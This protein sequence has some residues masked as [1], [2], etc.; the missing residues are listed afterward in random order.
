MSREPKMSLREMR[1]RLFGGRG[2]GGDDT[3]TPGR[4]QIVPSQERTRPGE[5]CM[6]PPAGETPPPGTR[7]EQQSGMRLP[8]LNQAVLDPETLDQLFRDIARC[9]QVLEVIPRFSRQQLV[10]HCSISLQ[11]GRKLLRS[12]EARAIQLRYRYEEAEWWDTLIREREGVRI[13]RIRHD[14]DHPDEG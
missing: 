5:P 12:G 13:V 1:A 10:E 8:E 7:C 9:T 11:Q 2:L 6:V 4:S 3:P 14:F